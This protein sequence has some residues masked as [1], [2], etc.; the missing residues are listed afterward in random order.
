MM[1]PACLNL[2]PAESLMAAPN[3]GEHVG[4]SIT[5]KLITNTRAKLITNASIIRVRV[6]IHVPPAS[7]KN[8]LEGINHYLFIFN[9]P[10]FSNNSRETVRE[11][12]AIPATYSPRVPVYSSTSV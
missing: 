11:I 3:P 4:A 6:R 10:I 5:A 8:I 12:H 7:I 1:A 9:N 2:A